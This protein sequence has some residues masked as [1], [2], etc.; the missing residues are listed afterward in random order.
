MANWG[1]NPDSLE[2]FELV[3]GVGVCSEFASPMAL[4]RTRFGLTGV[5][6]GTLEPDG[7]D[8]GA[9]T[10]EDRFRFNG[11]DVSCLKASA[12]VIDKDPLL[13]KWAAN[14]SSK[15]SS[16]VDCRFRFVSCESRL[17]ARLAFGRGVTA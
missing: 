6:E 10:R 1:C 2:R 8:V 9:T 4:E 3:G 12:G 14:S 17:T 11:E 5:I 16:C 7:F 13:C 15:S